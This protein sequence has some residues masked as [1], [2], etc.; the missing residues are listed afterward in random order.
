MRW[1]SYHLLGTTFLTAILYIA[2]VIAGGAL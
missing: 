1:N 2:I